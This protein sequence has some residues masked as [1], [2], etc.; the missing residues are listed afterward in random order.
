[1]APNNLSTYQL[2]IIV[3]LIMINK[4][5]CLLQRKLRIY[6]TNEKVANSYSRLRNW[7]VLDLRLRFLAAFMDFSVKKFKNGC[8]FFIFATAC[9]R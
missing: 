2:S 8:N 4:A 6:G 9:C 5:Y 1:M 7:S 3:Y